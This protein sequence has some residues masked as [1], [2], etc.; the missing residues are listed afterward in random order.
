MATNWA[1]KTKAAATAVP[2]SKSAPAERGVRHRGVV[3]SFTPKSYK[4]GSFGVEIKYTAEGVER[5]IY[6]NVVLKVMTDKGALEA[7]QYGES[8]LKRRLQAFGLTSE[9]INKFPIPVIPKDAETNAEAYKFGDTPV[10]LYLIDEEY[11]GK[12]K[13]RVKAVYLVD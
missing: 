7:T 13:K 5:P 10:V 4:T 8:T 9:Q 2:L 3:E 11:M 6:E 12:A 1:N